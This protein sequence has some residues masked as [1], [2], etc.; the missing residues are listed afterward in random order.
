MICLDSLAECLYERIED[1]LDYFELDYRKLKNR[2]VS[3]CPVHKGDNDSGFSVYF[4]HDYI[5]W[6][7]FTRGCESN[8][9][10]SVFGLVNALLDNKY[11]REHNNKEVI[12]WSSNFC[13]EI[14]NIT[15]SDLSMIRFNSMV[16]YFQPQQQTR[17]LHIDINKV[18][19]SLIIPP[20]YYLER[21]FG[22][23]I[24][25]K[26]CVGLCTKPHKEMY[27]RI[28]FPIFSDNKFDS[29][30]GCIGRSVFEKCPICKGYH[31]PDEKC[32]QYPKWLV[33]DSFPATEYFYNWWSAK[34][35]IKKSGSV[36]IVEGQGDVLKLEQAGIKNSIGL[37]GTGLTEHRKILLEK[38]GA[39]T[40][41]T[42]GD[43]DD[44][45]E[46]MNSKIKEELNLLYNVKNIVPP[47]KDIGDLPTNKQVIE[48]LKSFNVP[49]V[50]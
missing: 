45:G 17:L 18:K 34:D 26:Y 10:K 27:N 31:N 24:L 1:V 15:E 35:Y 16:K 30:I 19:N 40:I 46:N 25:E 42:C 43:N 44:A 47:N 4:D 48:L 23:D 41:Y 11:D 36:I 9:S 12:K 29:V 8:Y 33:N 20:E 50:N 21:G 49:I 37:L 32:N 38:S 22:R 2:Y 7:C 28:V 39:L 13:G 14:K 5:T 3:S 6:K